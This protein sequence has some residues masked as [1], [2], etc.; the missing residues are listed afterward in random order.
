[1]KPSVLQLSNV[2]A[3]SYFLRASRYCT[4][5]LPGYF[6]FQPLLN[7]LNR[8]IETKNI[9]ELIKGKSKVNPTG[10]DKDYPRLFD[11][12]NYR[13]LTNKDGNY[14]WRPL[15]ILNP[16]IYICLR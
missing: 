5:P 2:A 4:I 3:R 11:G 8:E 15:Q 9:A 10:N 16:V 12:V 13:F 14:A 7:A 1:M 6:D